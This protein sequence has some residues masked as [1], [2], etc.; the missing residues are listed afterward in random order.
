MA[1]TKISSPET[2]SGQAQKKT[3]TRD[4]G[5]SQAGG[6]RELLVAL[7]VAVWGELGVLPWAQEKPRGYTATFMSTSS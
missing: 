1:F 2:E 7:G 6:Q 3:R 4:P 5:C